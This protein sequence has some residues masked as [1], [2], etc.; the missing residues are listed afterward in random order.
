MSRPKT[1]KRL[2]KKH[3]VR[4]CLVYDHAEYEFGIVISAD[5][6]LWTQILW[7][8]SGL[9]K[10]RKCRYDLLQKRYEYCG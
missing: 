5:E 8:E 10:H 1:P 4:G 7:S 6:G 9:I 2:Q 3:I